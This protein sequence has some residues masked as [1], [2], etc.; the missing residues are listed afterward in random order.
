[1]AGA[2]R[3]SGSSAKDVV[4]LLKLMGGPPQVTVA[5]LR[6]TIKTLFLNQGLKKD[7]VDKLWTKLQVCATTCMHTTRNRAASLV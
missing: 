3:A 2:M 6:D 5:E 4:M 7:G 1:M